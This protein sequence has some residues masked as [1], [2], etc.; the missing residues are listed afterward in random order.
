MN[1]WVL[2]VEGPVPSIT[3]MAWQGSDRLRSP[4][5]RHIA[6]IVLANEHVPKIH[7]VS[8]VLE[9]GTYCYHV[10]SAMVEKPTSTP[11]QSHHAL[12]RCTTIA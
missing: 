5:D 1:W 8:I 3:A 11:P 6:A 4:V 9:A 10:K 2:L 12:T 7:T